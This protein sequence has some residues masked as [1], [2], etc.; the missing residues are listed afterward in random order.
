MTVDGSDELISN[1]ER[2][3][4]SGKSIAMSTV[5]AGLTVYANAAKNASPGTI[6]QETGKYLRVNGE[7]VSGRAGLIRFPRRG[8]GQDGP[9]GV[10][11]ELG[12]KFISPRGFIRSALQSAMPSARAAMRRAAEQRIAKLSRR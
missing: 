7:K 11:L 6:K 12:T 9:H 8:D 2:I 4:K 10:Y 5:N 3:Q 1:I